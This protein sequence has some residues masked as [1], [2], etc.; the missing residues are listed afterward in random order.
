METSSKET[1]YNVLFIQLYLPTAHFRIPFTYQRRH[2]Y[3]IPP[4]STIIG[5]LCNLLGI[6]DRNK[7]FYYK[8]LNNTNIYDELKKLKIS[9]SGNFESKITE[10]IWFRNLSIKNHEGRFGSIHNRYVNGHIEHIGGQSPVYLDTLN[11][12]TLNLHFYHENPSVLS[13]IHQN[14]ENPQS[15]L[16]TL[17]IG[18]AEDIFIIQ[19]LEFVSCQWKRSDGN[20]KNF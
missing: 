2:T 20:Y 16:E 3:P 19:K 17:H 6:D 7:T 13:Y 11:N 14:L 4:Y 10:M 5:F 8:E 12:F 1:L 9:I 15:K 18:R